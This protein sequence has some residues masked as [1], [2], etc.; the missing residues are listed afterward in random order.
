VAALSFALAGALTGVTGWTSAIVYG[1]ASFS[2]GL[3]LGFKA[4]FASVIGGFGTLRG[5]VA[6]AIVLA[7]AETGWSALFSTV[8][9]DVA[10]F[11]LIVLI[12]V[13]R[14]QGLFGSDIQVQDP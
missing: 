6:G 1:G 5:A 10:V 13:V 3:M 7:M 9:R 11:G 8:Y 4:M 12:L 14:P 2:V